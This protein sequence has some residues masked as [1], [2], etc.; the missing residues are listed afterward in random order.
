MHVQAVALVLREHND[1][2]EPAIDEVRERKVD[3]SILTT[4]GDGWLGPYS[5]ERH[6]A[7]ARAT[8]END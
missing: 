4:V 7:L 8:S 6:K 5:R 1:A 2:S 3:E